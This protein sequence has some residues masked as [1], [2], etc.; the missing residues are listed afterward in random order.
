MKLSKKEYIERFK[1][2]EEE[3]KDE[4]GVI[5]REEVELNSEVMERIRKLKR[6]FIGEEEFDS[7]CDEKDSEDWSDEECFRSCWKDSCCMLCYDYEG[8][9]IVIWSGRDEE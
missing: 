9:N 1:E 2:I 7:E 5:N 8:E 6:E 4:R 3:I